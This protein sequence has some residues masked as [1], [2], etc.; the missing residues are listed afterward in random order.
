MKASLVRTAGLA[1]SIVVTSFSP[2]H[3]APANGCSIVKLRAAAKA[4]A[5][6]SKALAKEV[7]GKTLDLSRCSE[8]LTGSFAKAE[9]NDDCPTTLDFATAFDQVSGAA[10]AVFIDLEA[11]T[12][13]ELELRCLLS[14][15]KA[16]TKYAR[17][18]SEALAKRM[19]GAYQG[20]SADFEAC[21]TTHSNAFERSE[22]G[23]C[24]TTGDSRA[25]RNS[26]GPGYAF[27]PAVDWNFEV[28]GLASDYLHYAELPGA[29][30][31]NND[32]GI[33]R[34]YQAN[35]AGADLSGSIVTD[36]FFS[37]V[38]LTEADFTGADLTDTRIQF[39]IVTGANLGTADLTRL[40]GV[41]LTG[42]PAS[43][44][45]TW[46]C[47]PP[48][49]AGPT[50]RLQGAD[51]DGLDLSGTD[52]SN[53]E[54]YEA[55]LVST[56]LAGAALVDTSMAYANFTEADLAGADLS[57]VSAYRAVFAGADLTGADLTNAYLPS[58]KLSGANLTG[59]DLSTAN[60][61]V[62]EATGLVA[63]PTAL[64]ADW[65]CISGNLIGPD[66]FLADADLSG[67]DLSGMNLAEIN[68]LD[69]NLTG[70]NFAGTNL[71]SANLNGANLTGVDLS[72][73]TLTNVQGNLLAACPASLPA[74]WGCRANT[75]VGPTANI[76]QI[77]FDNL[78]F[79]GLDL[80]NAMFYI[81]DLTGVTFA[82]ADLTNIDFYLSTCPD[83]YKLDSLSSCCTHLID[84]P[85]TCSSP[86]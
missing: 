12:V 66:A 81:C 48:V 28:N 2:S 8:K 10:E 86:P 27:L 43:L 36:A 80:T 54:L 20:M 73:A 31:V 79:S 26:A 19:S 40:R 16:T 3:A 51:L 56:N 21:G 57:D 15:V 29:Y 84:A 34:F 58:V 55:S 82:G 17:C 67:L 32:L 44:P 37:I 62:V 60:L 70:V 63:C 83:G 75:L 46:Q 72:T 33:A 24:A 5:C 69:A 74:G 14:K 9:A 47:R 30:L 49:L 52:L 4:F 41:G 50:A 78:D 68:F 85:A 22:T 64:P 77:Q 35:L 76:R 18:Q 42:C 61:A 7:R 71:S 38:D 11:D 6:V 1:V 53:A 39:S 23:V 25:V 45:G 13:T 65:E 59:V